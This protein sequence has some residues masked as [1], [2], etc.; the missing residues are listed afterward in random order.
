MLSL[1]R[2]NALPTLGETMAFLDV[3][4]DAVTQVFKDNGKVFRKNALVTAEQVEVET[5]IVTI[6]GDGFVETTNTAQPGSF[7]VT[8][9]SGERYIL[10]EDN[11]RAR[12]QK[13][14]TAGVYRARGFILAIDNPTAK[15][16]EILA[17]WGEPQF[18]DAR[19]LL[20]VTLD[21]PDDE[22]V[23]KDR[24]IIERDAFEQTYEAA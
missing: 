24:Y 16:I 2:V 23:G 8:N 3:H 20:A 5:E 21:G 4:S 22:A 12:Y 11:F 10:K 7:I 9:P 1:G 13:T 18:G 6:V 15:D 14:D 17:P 19:C